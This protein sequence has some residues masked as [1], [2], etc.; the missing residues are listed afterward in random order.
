M[1]KDMWMRQSYDLANGRSQMT[2]VDI[3]SNLYEIAAS[4]AE[5]IGLPEDELLCLDEWQAICE[6]ADQVSKGKADIDSIERIGWAKKYTRLVEKCGE[7]AVQSGGI[8]ALRVCLTFDMVAPKGP[9]Y[10][11]F[12]KKTDAP[13]IVSDEM[14]EHYVTQPP[15]GTRAK[16]RSEYIRNPNYLRGRP[17]NIRWPYVELA[18]GVGKYVDHL[19][20]YQTETDGLMPLAD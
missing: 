5:K 20:P 3:Q 1:G 8:F 19:H 16:V 6:D 10:E 4:A 13:E 9:L 14:V 15:Q 17:T 11:H 18:K 2:V 12:E 7:G